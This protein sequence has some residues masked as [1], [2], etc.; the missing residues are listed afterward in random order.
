VAN[1]LYGIG[2]DELIARNNN[3]QEQFFHQ[4]RLGNT[5]AV[6]GI[7]GAV[8]E[9][10][11]YDAFGAP[12]FRYPNGT[13]RMP[14]ETGI[15]NRFLFTGREWVQRY[16]FYEYRARAYNP[17]LG[18]FMSEDPIGFAA[19]DT[20]L[21]RYCGGD[22]VNY[23]DPFGLV[24]EVQ[25]KKKDQ[26]GVGVN[27]RI[28]YGG[29][30]PNT[31]NPMDKRNWGDRSRGDGPGGGSAR[32]WGTTASDIGSRG[33]GLGDG[34]SGGGSRGFGIGTG[35]TP[36]P[37]LSPPSPYTP[38]GVSIDP[39]AHLRATSIDE[40][41]AQTPLFDRSS[42]PNV[43]SFDW[44]YNGITITENGGLVVGLQQR[45][46]LNQ[47]GITYR[48]GGGLGLGQGVSV[49]TGFQSGQ[50]T[51]WNVQ[52][53]ASGGYIIGGALMGT[54]GHGSALN[55]SVGFGIGAGATVTY[56]PTFF[57]PWPWR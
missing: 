2:I 34:G 9:H 28:G 10:Y 52:G 55:A 39:F 30:R 25:P 21:F 19:G 29:G 54:H 49:T 6:T 38:T 12:S 4:D 26:G 5:G 32:D 1:N 56:G 14:N 43:P 44:F 24:S 33:G 22:P 3:G 36:T 35:V 15:N 48:V 17:F 23:V 57:V 51:G 46:T 11:R 31:A 16:G 41:I 20:N 40:L 53:S 7:N 18:R 50:V 42:F 37:L 47:Q 13:E 45:L 27:E 8:L